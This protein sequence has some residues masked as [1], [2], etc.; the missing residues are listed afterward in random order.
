MMVH[1]VEII[2]D[3]ESSESIIYRSLCQLYCRTSGLPF[4]RTEVL[5]SLMLLV[6]HFPYRSE[7][8][9]ARLGAGMRL[10]QAV[11]L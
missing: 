11:R 10:E 8:V 9:L 3:C 7:R 4:I 5:L 6:S 2:P 1:T